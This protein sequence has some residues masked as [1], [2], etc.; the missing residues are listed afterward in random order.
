MKIPYEFQI[1]WRYTRVGKRTSGKGFISFTALLSMCGIALG[2]S[3]LIIVLSVM[4]GF[5]RDV[6]DRMLSIFSHIEIFSIF[7]PSAG[8][9]DW[10]H[11]I[12]KALS[13]THVVGA[14]PYFE[15]QALLGYGD[16]MQGLLL[17]G[18]DPDLEPQVSVLDSNI[19]NNL[20]KKLL[21]GQF[22]LI[23]GGM[24]A[25]SLGISI[26]EKVAVIVPQEMSSLVGG[27]PRFK[28]FTIVGIF[29]SG[30]VEL[31]SN[32]VFLNIQDAQALYRRT[33]PTGVKLK[34]SDI[35]LA[36]RVASELRS[37]LSRDVYIRDWTKQHGSWFAA[38]RIEKRMMFVVLT[39]IIA[40]AAFN[41]VSSLVM[42]VM[43]K[44][45]D[46][47]ILRTLGARSTS[48][49][50]VFFVQGIS[51]GVAGIL[52]GAVMGIL[53][54]LN[55][56]VVIPAIERFLGIQFI[57]TGVYFVNELPVQLLWSD[58]VKIICIAFFF[59]VLATFYPSFRAAK[60][61]PAKALRYNC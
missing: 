22:G 23:I 39:L 9:K 12:K 36:P 41:L 30:H 32:L 4:N 43:D 7:G 35:H 31:D 53:I 17:K 46:I 27:I 56:P 24:F 60:I 20:F 59:C 52:I 44:Q 3:V 42:T 11:Q 61:Q 28:H 18:I 13:H 1:G 10:N 26:G 48:I 33:T 8:L 54:T 45:S 34:L 50:L 2:V 58:I 49:V 47:A 29:R 16:S 15:G 5:Q 25:D 57:P 37:I 55:I 51:I 40:V 38:V 19:N 6:R 21:P 14:A